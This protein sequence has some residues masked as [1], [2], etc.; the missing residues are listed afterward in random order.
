MS[1]PFKESEFKMGTTRICSHACSLNGKIMKILM[2]VLLI[3]VYLPTKFHVIPSIG[4]WAIGKVP[5]L[6]EDYIN[7]LHKIGQHLVP[8]VPLF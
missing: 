7:L 6:S 4:C 8:T 5:F 1:L 2:R 3:G